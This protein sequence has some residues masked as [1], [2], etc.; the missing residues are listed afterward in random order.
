MKMA[1]ETYE[2]MK[3]AFELHD[4]DGNG[5]L[6]GAELKPTFGEFLT[7]EELEQVIA[8]ADKNGDGRLNFREFVKF[9]E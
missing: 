5:F 7:E 3:A 6:E 8:F 9:F 1:K 4:K 2:K